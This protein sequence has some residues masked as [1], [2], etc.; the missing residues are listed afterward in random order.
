MR[1]TVGSSPRT[2]PSSYSF[3]PDIWHTSDYTVP[4]VAHTM[5][6]HQHGNIHPGEGRP[7]N[8][9]HDKANTLVLHFYVS[10]IYVRISV[11]IQ[12]ISADRT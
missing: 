6:C 4:V 12:G 11:S 3:S 10:L 8:A 7:D 5:A 9:E 2:G 1:C